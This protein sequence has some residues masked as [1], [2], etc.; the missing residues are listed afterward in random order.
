TGEVMRPRFLGGAKTPVK[1]GADPLQT[2]GGWGA[3]PD[4]PLFART[5]G[6]PVWDPLMGRGIVAP[7]GDFPAAHPPVKSALLET[8][9]RDF[10]AHHFRLKHLVR[11][12]M[13]SRTYQLSAKPNET[14][15]DDETNFSHALVKP[16]QAE[17]L[18][19][20]LVQV[21]GVPVQYNGYPLGVRA[22]Q[23]A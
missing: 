4:N 10:V 13:N 21:A 16:L 5:Q 17:Q 15:R 19:D 12:I 1:P 9:T 23:L 18:L 11:T 8:L 14:N 7:A 2:P 20:A 3:G 6:K 22:G